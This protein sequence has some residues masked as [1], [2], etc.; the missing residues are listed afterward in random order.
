MSNNAPLTRDDWINASYELLITRGIDSIRIET[1]AKNLKIT[2]GSFYHHFSGRE[3]L[4]QAVIA[5]WRSK[6]TENIIYRLDHAKRDPREQL[7]QLFQLPFRGKKARDIA[8]IELAIRAWARREPKVQTILTEVDNY[9]LQ[10]MR[11]I[12]REMG[13]QDQEA[14]ERAFLFYSTILSFSLLKAPAWQQSAD[15][16]LESLFLSLFLLIFPEQATEH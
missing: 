3:D 9:R 13:Y 12:I 10:Y 8:S 4:M 14:H 11:T 1:L 16:N 2:R 6:A 7:F 5:D 15:E